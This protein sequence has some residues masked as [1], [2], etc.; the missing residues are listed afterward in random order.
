L[1][2]QEKPFNE[3]D[4]IRGYSPGTPE[5][6]DLEEALRRKS[7][8]TLELPLLM[9]GRKVWTDR[10]IDIPCPHDPSKILARAC[11]AGKEEM[12][13]AVET[14]L[15]AHR[16]WS[17]CP[18]EQRSA[19][20]KRAADLLAG[21][22]RTESIADIMLNLSKNPFEAEIDL[23]ELVDFWRFNVYY[24]DQIYGDQPLQGP[25]EINRFEWRPLEGFVLAITPFNFYSIAGNLPS[26]P[27]LCGNTTIWKPAR[28]AILCNYGIMRVLA[29]AGLPGG[30][31]NFLPFSGSESGPLMDHP[32][33]AGLHFTGSY[34]TF[35]KLQQRVGANMA[36][37]RSFPRVVGETGGKDFLVV[38]PSADP[39]AVGANIIRGG[40]EYQGQKC[41]AVSRVYLPESLRE[42][43]LEYL[44]REIPRIPVGPTDSL[45]TFMGALI[46]AQAF[47]KVMGYIDV[48]R[49]DPHRYRILLGGKGREEAGWFVEPTVIETTDPTG[50]LM[51]EE[52]FGP[53]VTIYVYPDAKWTETL[54]L[55]D[56]STDYALTGAV[57]ARERGAIL[58]AERTL[59]YAA[60][61]FYVNDKPTGAVVGRQPFGGS[62]H[63]GTN[64]KA[65]FRGNLLRWLSPRI[66]KEN[67]VPAR[68]WRRPYMVEESPSSS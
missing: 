68:D 31:I 1:S 37:Y 24:L 2:Q 36:R 49:S 34:G 4:H 54:A 62:R 64:D 47:R 14:A 42:A 22:H 56:A 18:W 19:V 38:H 28:S 51:T 50:K 35:M 61:N 67:T 16:S 53:V 7:S 45:S 44:A 58:E 66:I 21:P 29:E 6:S 3:A 30:V 52:I 17:E 33:L 60:G 59:R 57:F 63:S 55:C 13:L 23:A 32:R 27:A 46:D 12:E 5:R 8:K 43:V 11:T 39:V 48:A 10:V 25:R 65:G 9:G 26:A 41:S 20:F 15:D 40:F